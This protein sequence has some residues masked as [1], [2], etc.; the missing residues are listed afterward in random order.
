MVG[1]LLSY[2]WVARVGSHRTL[3]NSDQNLPAG[4]SQSGVA[5]NTRKS[6][7]FNNPMTT[8][9]MER[10]LDLDDYGHQYQ[11]TLGFDH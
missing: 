9:R 11:I 10:F 2:Q 3:L 5:V 8:M 1:D 4:T 6:K 7:V